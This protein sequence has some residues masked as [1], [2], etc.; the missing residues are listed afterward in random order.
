MANTSV[1]LTTVG[2]G[3]AVDPAGGTTFTD[4]GECIEGFTNTG[5]TKPEID[6]TVWASTA[7][8]YLTGMGDYG[9]WQCSGFYNPGS[10]GAVAIKTLFE[11]GAVAAWKLTFT[12]ASDTTWTVNGTVSEFSLSATKDDAFRLTWSVKLSGAPVEA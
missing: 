11:S 9:T 1:A 6:V 4:L 7:K 5:G 3:L 8:E 10:T 12:D 2:A